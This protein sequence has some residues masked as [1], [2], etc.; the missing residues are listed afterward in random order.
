MPTWGRQDL[1]TVGTS[2]QLIAS[3]FHDV[4]WKPGGVTIDWDTVT[5]VGADTLLTGGSTIKA[6]EKYIPMG[7]ILA[8]ITAS[9]KYGPHRTNAVDG[10]QTLTPGSCWLMNEDWAQNPVQGSLVTSA[11]TDHPPVFN[12]G[13]VW[14]SR[15]KVGGANEATL[16]QLL[17]AMPGITPITM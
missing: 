4:G 8:K 7:E 1:G 5:A 10:R 14:Q 6:G 12:R 3:D 9:G 13:T 11:A 15:L 2:I 17:A 16:A